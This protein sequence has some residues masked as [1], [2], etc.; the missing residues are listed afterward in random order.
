MPNGKKK[1]GSGPNQNQG[2]NQGQG[3]NQ[4]QPKPAAAGGSTLGGPPNKGNQNQNQNQPK[5]QQPQQQQ[6]NKNNNKQQAN[7]PAKK[8]EVKKE[9]E[10]Q[11]EEITIET[12]GVKSQKAK[13]TASSPT[14]FEFG[15]FKD[16]LNETTDILETLPKNVQTRVKA[17]QKLQNTHTDFEKEFIKELKALETKYEKLY[18]PL[19]EKRSQIVQGEYEPTKDDL[20]TEDQESFS[21]EGTEKGIPNFWATVLQKNDIIAEMI[22]PKDQEALAYL[23]EVKYNNTVELQ[24]KLEFFFSENPFFTNKVLYKTYFYEEDPETGEESGTRLEGTPIDWKQ[25]KD[26]TVKIVKKKIKQKGKVKVVN[27]REQCDSFFNFFNPKNVPEGL[28]DEE[29]I[30]SED[31]ELVQLVEQDFEIGNIFKETIIPNAVRWFTGE[32]SMEADDDHDHEEDDEL[33]EDDEDM[34][35]DD[36]PP[37]LVAG[38]K[39]GAGTSP[40]PAP[41]E[42]PPECK[43][44]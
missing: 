8:E 22:T 37:R 34:D 28:E 40:T 38:G 6:Q 24:L 39:S 19:Y 23:T 15:S 18:A 9:K 27:K 42:Q 29:E 7:A 12:P 17:L 14:T 21:L 10:V 33:D 41:V 5:N 13:P 44:Q 26:L 30:T 43:Q 36:E 31:G 1:G 25:G 11:V 20:R 2:Q 32:L 35:D 4:N 3:Q 16:S